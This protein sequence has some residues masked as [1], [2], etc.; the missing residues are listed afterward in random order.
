M[1][2]EDPR[3]SKLGL[4][5][6]S[7]DLNIVHVKGKSFF[8]RHFPDG[9][10]GYPLKYG[11]KGLYCRDGASLLGESLSLA[12]WLASMGQ[13][14]SCRQVMIYRSSTNF[15]LSYSAIAV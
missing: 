13:V 6:S 10:G 15:T 1:S 14:G 4:S 5:C 2:F 12:I 3:G 11:L 8:Y 7:D 9:S